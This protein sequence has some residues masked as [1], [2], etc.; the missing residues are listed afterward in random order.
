MPASAPT[1]ALSRDASD[2]LQELD[3]DV[4]ALQEVEHHDVEGYDLLDYLAA[5]TGA[6][7]YCRP[8]SPAWKQALRQCDI[9]AAS[10]PG[11]KAGGSE[12]AGT[13]TARGD[14]CHPRWQRGVCRWWRHIWG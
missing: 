3:V 13:R 2:V 6:H 12:P 9:D 10:Y 11:L 5:K 7:A 1:A 4:V 14:R 8:K